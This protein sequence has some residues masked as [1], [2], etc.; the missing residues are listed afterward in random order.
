MIGGIAVAVAAPLLGCAG[1]ASRRSIGRVVVVGGGYGGATAARYLRLWSDGLVD[2]TLVERNAE[3]VSCPMSNLVIGGQRQLADITRPYSGL[4]AAGVRRIQGEA[5]AIDAQARRVRLADGRSLDYDRAV[6]SPGVDF[7]PGE[8]IGL[9]SPAAQQRFLHGWKAGPQTVALRRQLEAM[10]DGGVFALTIPAAPFRCPPGPYERACLVADYFK[11]SKPRSKV[12]VLDANPEIQ[13]KKV[14][15]ERA[16]AEHYR[17]LIEYR[18]NNELRQVDAAAGIAKLDFD[19]VKADVINV[20]PPQRAADIARSAGL[21]NINQRWVGVHWL[22]MEAT[23]VPGIHVL[24]DATFAAP[25]MP[26]SGHLANQHAKV[27]AAAIIQLLKGEPVNA[28]PVVAN[29]CYSYVTAGE[30]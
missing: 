13:S 14:L 22:T 19:D 3:F 24:G 4:E 10:H 30:A 12:L 1:A 27:A 5:V 6:V 8:V 26:K 15:F 20:V 25:L 18:P 29:T 7:T 9:D 11:R 16:F 21:V 28:T 2:V 17:D 23:A